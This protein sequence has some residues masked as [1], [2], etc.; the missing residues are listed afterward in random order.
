MNTSILVKILYVLFLVILIKYHR[1]LW[2]YV[3][4]NNNKIFDFKQ[5]KKLIYFEYAFCNTC[6]PENFRSY[7]LVS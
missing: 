3:K 7:A 6:I 1:F 4:N 5:D 2:L